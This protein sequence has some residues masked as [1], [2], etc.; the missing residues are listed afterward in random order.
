MKRRTKKRGPARRG[1]PW[2]VLMGLICIAVGTGFFGVKYVVSPWMV[3][4][5]S[6]EEITSSDP[7]PIRE[8]EPSLVEDQ[9]NT[10]TTTAFAVQLGSFSTKEAAEQRVGELNAQG[11]SA[12]VQMRDNAWKVVSE[13]FSTKEEAREAA[14][15]WRDLTGDAFVVEI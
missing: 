7:D 3:R 5:T 14:V 6:G 10:V 4:Q 2:A 12:K 9:I 1:Y 11:I 15:R 13:G 8:E